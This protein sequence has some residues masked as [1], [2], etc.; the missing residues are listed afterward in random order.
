MEEKMKPAN[1]LSTVCG[2]LC[3][4]IFALCLTYGS[5]S[6]SDFPRGLYSGPLASSSNSIWQ[7]FVELNPNII[8]SGRTSWSNQTT[9]ADYM[10][11]LEAYNLKT[12]L[13]KGDWSWNDPGWTDSITYLIEHHSWGQYNQLQVEWDDSAALS[14]YEI[15]GSGYYY[16]EQ[17]LG[18]ESPQGQWHLNTG[19]TTPD[20]AL[21]GMLWTIPP[22]VPTIYWEPEY[23]Y[24][25]HYK[26]GETGRSFRVR[27]T[28]RADLDG[29]VP[30]DS[31]FLLR[32]QYSTLD[33]LYDRFDSLWVTV[34]SF[35][36]SPD[37]RQFWVEEAFDTSAADLTMNGILYE[38]YY[39]GGAD[40]WIDYIEYLDMEQAYQLIWNDEMQAQTLDMI[41]DECAGVQNNYGGLIAGWW[42]SNE[43][44]QQCFYAHGV[45]NEYLK[46]NGVLGTRYPH[47]PMFEGSRKHIRHFFYTA[48]PMLY[49]ADPYVFVYGGNVGDQDELSYLAAEFDT[50]YQLCQEAGIDMHYTAQAHDWCRG[51][52]W[53][54]RNPLRSEILAEAYIGLAHG[55]KGIYFFRYRGNDG[56]AQGD[57][58]HGLVDENFSHLGSLFADKW[59]AVHDVFAQ[60]DAIGDT[61]LLLERDAA[62]FVAQ[63][64]DFQGAIDNVY[65]TDD[66]LNQNYI[67]VGQFRLPP[68][69]EPD[70][71]IIVNRRT[72]G[73]RHITVET[74]KTSRYALRDL[75]TQQRFVSYT[76]DFEGIPFDSG[77]GRVFRLESF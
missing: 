19:L 45:I 38:L 62:F 56:N 30:S 75:Y 39:W 10:D 36:S 8:F 70:Y 9:I 65:F 69:T 13:S 33:H 44:R 71:L 5:L 21:K 73:D 54:M 66:P 43:G 1:S 3:A 41:A 67:E 35:Q 47:V 32:V 72:N 27:I 77:E 58:C 46:D 16:F 51:G 42:Q 61:L 15:N 57:T 6:G 24:P 20:T 53:S 74:D 63:K 31:V 4:L 50:V 29:T 59:Q 11:K 7:G 2:A 22:S 14:Q 55:A 68:S 26:F 23:D 48:K 52:V 18:E 25:E 34:D 28:A 17:D 64:P 60:L 40:V 49:E 76:G 37:W 12:V